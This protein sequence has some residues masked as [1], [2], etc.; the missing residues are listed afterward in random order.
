[1]N[2]VLHRGS[3][4]NLRNGGFCTGLEKGPKKWCRVLLPLRVNRDIVS[5]MKTGLL[6]GTAANENHTGIE[7]A[8]I[9]NLCLLSSGPP[10]LRSRLR[11]VNHVV[12]DATNHC[13]LRW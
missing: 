10:T 12:A 6:K 8:F 7:A 5:A 9:A 11:E 13:S 3:R 2:R 4:K 1:L